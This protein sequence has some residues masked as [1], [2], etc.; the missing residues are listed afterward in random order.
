VNRKTI[1][2]RTI[3]I[4]TT[5]STTH[6]AIVNGKPID[7]NNRTIADPMITSEA[8]SRTIVVKSLTVVEWK[9][10]TKP[11]ITVESTIVSETRSRRIVV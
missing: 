1:A 10:I 4:G 9:I 8:S 6:P 3:V 2:E 5:I 11:K 7:L